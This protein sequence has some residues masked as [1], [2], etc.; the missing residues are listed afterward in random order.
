[1]KLV[2][3]ITG[4]IGSGKTI[5]A[6]YLSKKY[7]ASEYQFS[8]ILM[9]ILDRL[10]MEKTRLNLQKLGA[11]L[12]KELGHDV[13]VNAMRKDIEKDNSRIIVIDGIRYKNEVEM[14]RKFKHN[15]LISVKASLRIR[16]ERCIKR[17]EK[18]E[19]SISFE[20]FLK[21]EKKATEKEI[22]KISTI[23]DYKLKNEGDEKELFKQV[24]EILEKFWKKV[25]FKDV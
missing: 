21:S 12:R 19:G 2:I 24:D 22:E 10:Y 9:D 8:K 18:G 20:D 11:S 1:M 7:L 15:M 5:L 17:G 25:M 16:Y 14:L 4:K 6:N 23:A 13:I 3:G